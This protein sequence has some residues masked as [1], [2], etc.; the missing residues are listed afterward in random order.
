ML[1]CSPT[2]F[3]ACCFHAHICT[4]G[5]GWSGRTRTQALGGRATKL[6]KDLV[7]IDSFLVEEANEIL[8]YHTQLEQANEI[9]E[10]HTQLEQANEI[11]YHAELNFMLTKRNQL[12]LKM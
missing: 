5:K 11:L 9:L 1:I 6:K 3:R 2:S 8:E 7:N 12:V 10:Y 4:C